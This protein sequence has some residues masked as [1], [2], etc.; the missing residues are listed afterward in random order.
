MEQ[1]PSCVAKF[2]PASQE[3]LRD[4]CKPKVHFRIQKSPSRAPILS[5]L[6]PV[7]ASSPSHFL[8]I[9]FNIIL[10]SKSRSS[11]HI[12]AT[13]RLVTPC[14]NTVRPPCPSQQPVQFD[15]SYQRRYVHCLH[16]TAKRKIPSDCILALRLPVIVRGSTGGDARWGR[17]QCDTDA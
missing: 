2:F 6:D 11:F 14:P 16:L 7:L 9:H 12:S 17:R 5:Q 8:K 13:V 4:L 3:I 1:S 10:P 15:F